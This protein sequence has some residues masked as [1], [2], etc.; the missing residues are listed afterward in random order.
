[1]IA[2]LLLACAPVHDVRPTPLMP[3]PA[4]VFEEIGVEPQPADVLYRRARRWFSLAFNDAETVLDLED[5]TRI[6]GRLRGP[7]LSPAE[8]EQN[9]YVPNVVYTC[10][11]MRHNDHIVLPY[12]VSDTFSNF[13]TAEFSPP[14]KAVC[15]RSH[16]L[17]TMTIGLAALMISPAM[18]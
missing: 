18:A 6:I 16:L 12:A 5:P 8:D 2:L 9:G 10:G 1:M 7:L 14:L 13:A 15:T 3:G 4:L 17:T 11:A